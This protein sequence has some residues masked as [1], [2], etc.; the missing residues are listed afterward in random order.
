MTYEPDRYLLDSNIFDKLVDDDAALEIAIQLVES[1]RVA[2]LSTHVQ[3]DEIK[4][5]PDSE[6]VRRLLKVPVEQVPTYGV[7][8]G[9]SRWGMARFSDAEPFESLRGDNRDH[10][11]DALIAAT[12]QFEQAT[13]VTEDRTLR[14]RALKQGID[15]IKWR[16]LRDRLLRLGGKSPD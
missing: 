13:L 2:F 4:R 11:R 6:R 12:A 8:F 10:T 3:T 9:V 1:G 5:T 7:V 16:E 15:T 14:N